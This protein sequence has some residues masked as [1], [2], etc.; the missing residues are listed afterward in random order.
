MRNNN[1]AF[2]NKTPVLDQDALQMKTES[3][4]QTEDKWTAKRRITSRDSEW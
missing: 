2:I 4:Q 1:V 3:K